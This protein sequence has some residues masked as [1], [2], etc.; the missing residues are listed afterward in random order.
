MN[1]LLN[2]LSKLDWVLALGTLAYGAYH[3]DWL[4]LSAGVLGV[5][6]AWY[7]PADK[8]KVA[9][10]KYFL[11]KKRPKDDSAK[12]LQEEAFYAEALQETQSDLAAISEPEGP[13][14]APSA[15]FRRAL[16]GYA[17]VRLNPSRHNQLSP[18]AFD[19]SR[20]VPEQYC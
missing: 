15:D 3:R 19:I 11:A 12:L 2:A 8:V 1:K 6:V 5:A 20:Q 14:S 18:A 4:I 13:P 16:G 17:S 9:L 7:R 10:E